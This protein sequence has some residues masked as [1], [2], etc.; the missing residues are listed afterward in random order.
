MP[1]RYWLMKSEPDVYSIHDLEREGQAEWDGVRN[2]QARNFMRD[3]MRVGDAVLF[4]HSNAKP[5]GVAGVARV[6]REAYPDHTAHDPHSKYHDPKSTPDE[7]RWFMVDVEHVESFPEV[8]PLDTLRETPGLEDM[9]VIKK[10]IRLSVQPVAK[11]EFD[12]VVKLGRRGSK[13]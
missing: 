3:E 11:R 9:M 2:Y 12:M 5:P 13:T 6:C 10:G 4:Y 1:R 7:P 8:I